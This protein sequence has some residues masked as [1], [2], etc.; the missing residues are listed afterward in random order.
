MENF[1]SEFVRY[2]DLGLAAYREENWSVAKHN[3]LKAAENLCHLALKSPDKVKE[4]YFQ[5]AQKL[6][7]MV[8]KI[9]V[10]EINEEGSSETK[11]KTKPLVKK[12]SKEE[13]SSTSFE[14]IVGLSAVKEEIF[15]KMVYPFHYPEL[16]EK[17]GVKKGG[18]ILLFGP[19]GTGKTMIARAIAQELDASF[20]PIVPSQIMDKLVGESE[21]NIAHI[22]AEARSQEKAVIFI[23]ELEALAPSRREDNSPIMQRIVPQILQELEGVTQYPE[24]NLL[25]LG[26][27]NEPWL[28]DAA[29]LRP[30]RF[31]QIF[32]IPLPD[33]EAREELFR[34]QLSHRPLAE[35]INYDQ[36]ALVSEGY[37][38]ADIVGVCQQ[39]AGQFFREAI[40]LQK[41][42]AIAQEDIEIAIK[43]T[44]PSVSPKYL[45]SYK[46]FHL[47][48][49]S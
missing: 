31:D 40:R 45:E 46:N 13:S 10:V 27:T 3:L 29:F 25:F 4:G 5:E 14:D 35:G 17:Y 44:P 33:Q 30:G 32:Y 6:R 8:K 1:K 36:L 28:I 39:V 41:T 37:S 48:K 23:D 11:L 16:A 2:K 19:P 38:G 24:S 26:A 18:G 15:T 20:F 49:K 21:K 43:E 22:F 42:S 7:E 9:P 47:G 12:N 34:R